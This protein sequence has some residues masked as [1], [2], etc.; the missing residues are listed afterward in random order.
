[1]H[2]STRTVNIQVQSFGNYLEDMW[3]IALILILISKETTIATPFVWIGLQLVIALACLFIFRQTGPNMFIPFVV[4]TIILSVLFL[5]GA[6]FWLFVLGAVISIWRIQARFNTL[7]NEQTTDSSFSLL[8]LATFLFVHLTCFLLSYEAYRLLLYTVFITGIA[9]FVGIRLFSV[10]MNSSSHNSLKK[11]NLLSIYLVSIVSVTSLSAIIYFLAPIIRKMVDVLFGG[12][13]RVVLIPF[14]PLMSYFE[15]LVSKLQMRQFE[16]S[17]HVSVGEQGEIEK[18]VF[19]VGTNSNFPIG[20]I[21]LGLA[22]IAIL[23]FI[24]YLLKNKP[25]KLEMEQIEIE[26]ENNEIN[27]IEKQK[28]Q[29]NS[30]YKVETSLLRE[31]YVQFEMEAHSYE[32]ERNKSETVR[33]WFKRMN[34]D[35]DVVFFQL[36]EEVRYGSHSISSDKAELFLITLN[37]TRRKFFIEKDV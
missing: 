1:M 37:E 24:R 4:P 5:F 21:F 34:W 22:T 29:S 9:L 17:G 11:N 15:D 23:F 25:E 33:E 30:L 16:E 36:Y 27:E 7:Q 10:S 28:S 14:G 26:Y 8:F 12:I 13:L 3:F 18:K 31:K 2:N 20:W 6:P 19:T 35:V 32:Y